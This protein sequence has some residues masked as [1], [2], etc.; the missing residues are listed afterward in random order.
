MPLASAPVLLVATS[1]A[2]CPLHM[3]PHHALVTTHA[4]SPCT[5][6]LHALPCRALVASCTVLPY[7]PQS[8]APPHHARHSHPH[9]PP[10]RNYG[11]DHSNNTQT[12]GVLRPPSPQ[13]TSTTSA[14]HDHHDKLR[15]PQPWRAHSGSRRQPS[16]ACHVGT[17][18]YHLCFLRTHFGSG[19]TK[20]LPTET[21]WM[22]DK[23]GMY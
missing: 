10:H 17:A 15:P 2:S 16:L 19:C 8:H 7:A 21:G 13:P 14:M 9:C 5:P 22:Q 3:P 23:D 6:P 1:C 4:V 11:H 12:T 20:Y 18:S